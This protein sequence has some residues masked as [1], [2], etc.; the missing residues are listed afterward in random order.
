MENV[1]SPESKVPAELRRILV[2]PLSG[3]RVFESPLPSPA[4]EN[5]GFFV[6]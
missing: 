5:A 6:W 3:P 2:S 1:S 4:L